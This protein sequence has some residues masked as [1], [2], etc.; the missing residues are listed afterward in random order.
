MANFSNGGVDTFDPAKGYLG[1]RLQQGVPLLD[2]DWNELEDIR[3]HVERML[4]LHYVGDGV[5]DVSGFQV[6]PAPAGAEHELV[7]GPGRCSVA[8]L[9]VDNPEPVAYSAQGDGN[10][11]P[12]PPADAPLVLT[13]YL[14]PIV[15]RIDATVDPDLANAQD[16]NVETC[17]RD[18]LSWA[19]RVARQPDV[20]PPGCYVLAEV[21]R[22]AG[23]TVV[24]AA[25][26]ADR[27][28]TRLSLATTV[29]RVGAAEAKAAALQKLL[30]DTRDWLEKVQVDLDR[31]FWQVRVDP[32]TV[33][34]YFGSRVRV[35]AKVTNRRNEPIAGAVVAFSTDWGTLEPATVTTGANG[36]AAVDLVGVRNDVPMK[37]ADIAV[38]ERVSA[39]VSAAVALQPVAA[40]VTT[41]AIEYKK[42]A[43]DPDEMGM[44]SKYS[45]TGALV[46]IANDLPRGPIVLEPAWRTANVTVHVKESTAESIVKA[47][48][49]V[50]VRFGLWVR[51]WARS[52]VWEMTEHLQ[53]G[54]RVSDLIRQGLDTTTRTLDH[55]I[56]VQDLLPLTLQ[57]IADDTSRVMKATAFGDPDLGDDDLRGSGKLGQLLAE[58]ATAAIG[59]K[60][61]KAVALQLA[62]MVANDDLDVAAANQAMLKLD[63]GSSQI[64]AGLAQSQK[65]RFARVEA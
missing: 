45:P 21:T 14:E 15:E 50:Q 24:Q 2:R 52:K 8:G 4:R 51:D 58:E 48:G 33:E 41:K 35:Q 5:P 53:V 44:I 25:E 18:R 40:N 12:A 28:R 7:V 63:Q 43:F 61:Q 57:A 31:L 55:Q 6:L 9:E 19:V 38:L 17:V 60:T 11:L 37:F 62:T 13:V 27:R 20:P 34:A 59:A 22:A 23:S 54:A 29:D 1:I 26:I 39:K 56:L 36:I 3:R 65:Q 16:V 10:P 47:V 46:D 64:V 49:N 32:A 30:E 42:L